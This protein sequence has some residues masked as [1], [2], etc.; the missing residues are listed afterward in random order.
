MTRILEVRTEDRLAWVEPG[1]FNLDLSA[2]LRPLGFHYAPDPSS[3]QVSTIGGNVNTNAGGPHCLASGVTS[4][5]VLALDLAL[6]DGSLVRL[7]AEGPLDPGYD[8]RGFA[9]GQRGHA[10]RGHRGLRAPHAEPARPSARCCWTSP[11]SRT[12][13]APSRRSSRAGV[14]P[15]GDG[16]DGPRDRPRRRGVRPR[17]LPHR[18]GRRPPDRGR[19]ERARGR[20]GDGRD[21]A[22]GGGER[23]RHGARGGRRGRA[24]PAVEGPQVRVRR[25]R[26]DRTRTTTCTTAWSPGRSSRRSC[27]ACTRSRTATT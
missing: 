21:R 22:R 15:R 19:R 26:P 23:R 13:P 8:L 5:H 14:D 18:R 4:A 20:R 25:D 17:R 7:G 24:R 3:Q 10:R 11:T 2:H 12:A 16:D 6:H 27:R 9:V 1:V